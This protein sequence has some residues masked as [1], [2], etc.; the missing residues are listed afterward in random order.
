MRKA[1]FGEITN[2]RLTR[3]PY[4][5]Y[6]L[7][8]RREKLDE[9][10]QMIRTAVAQ[11]E[12]NGYI[13]DSLGWV[14]YRLGRYEEA[15]Q[16]MERAVELEPV[17]PIVND[18]LGDVLWMVGRK[19]EARFQWKRALSFDPEPEE[20]DRIRRKLELGL[21]AVLAEEEARHGDAPARTA[22][23]D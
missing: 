5:G 21:D 12:N 7:V 4:L 1:L 20:A 13:I 23:G 11:E 18:H 8:E 17:D 22:D 6:S 14:L 9:A 15:V 16:P 2:G 19:M 10:E 3:L